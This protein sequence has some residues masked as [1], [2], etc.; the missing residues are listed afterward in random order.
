M[1]DWADEI[2]A[3]L[4]CKPQHEQKTMDCDFAASIAAALRKAKADGMREARKSLNNL[5]GRADAAALW[6]LN[7]ALKVSADKIEKGEE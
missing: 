5:T 6:D 4:W 7:S 3:Q 1:T 2:A